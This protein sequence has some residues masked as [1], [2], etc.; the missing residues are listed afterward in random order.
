MLFTSGST[1][2]PKGV[3]V[4]HANLAAFVAGML[5]EPGFGPGDVMVAVASLSFDVAGSELW[6]PLSSGGR[7]AVIDRADVVDGHRLADRIAAA[8]A[9]MLDAPPTLL[10][11]LLAAGWTGGRH[12]RV[13]SGG[14]ALDPALARELLPLVGELWNAYGP[15]E[16]TINATLQRVVDADGSTVPIGPPVPG[17]HAY[18]VDGLGRLLPAGA[19]GELWVGGAG[20]ARG[21]AGRADLTAAAF[22]P[23]PF[24]PGGR[25]YRTGDLV[26]WLPGGTLDFA[27]RRDAQVKIRGYRIELGEVESV[28][29]EHPDVADAAVSV[30]G[31][32]AE[33]RLAA[34][35][36]PEGVDA[37]AVEAFASRRLPAYMV[38]RHWT[39]LAA[40]PTLA[41]GKVDRGALPAPERSARG[42]APRTATERLVAA[43]WSEVLGVAEIGLADSFFALG[44][45]SFA[46][47]RVAGRLRQ[48]LGC[49]VPVRALFEHPELADFTAELERLAL[50][51]LADQIDTV[52]AEVPA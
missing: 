5:R 16:T 20:V 22:V 50:A 48:A 13:I 31:A 19:V 51:Q 25:C 40:L 45:Q 32:G 17:A 11:A 27:G 47:T 28:L 14:E 24:R 26:R 44:G 21:Y 52:T 2:R 42:E 23:D 33:A 37:A 35:V 6:V 1:G 29:R 46:A 38:P 18:V 7:T 3:E 30:A 41:S 49:E 12:M 10:R 34:Y 43:T 36:T 15:T 9:T 39:G 4:T 8:G